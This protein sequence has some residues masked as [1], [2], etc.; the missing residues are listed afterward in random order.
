MSKFTYSDYPKMLNLWKT[1]KTTNIGENG[2][3]EVFSGIS[4]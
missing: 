1:G 4:A 2:T 3:S